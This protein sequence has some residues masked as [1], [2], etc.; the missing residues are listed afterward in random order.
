MRI[1]KLNDYLEAVD[2]GQDQEKL[3]EYVEG[4]PEWTKH[5]ENVNS[6]PIPCAAGD[7][8]P[9]QEWFE[10]QTFRPDDLLAEACEKL[11]WHSQPQTGGL[12]ENYYYEEVG[13]NG[14]GESYT[15]TSYVYEIIRDTL[16]CKTKKQMV[17]FLSSHSESLETSFRVDTGM[18]LPAF[19]DYINNYTEYEES[20]SEELTDKYW[21]VDFSLSKEV[22]GDHTSPIY[23]GYLIEGEVFN[24]FMQPYTNRDVF[25]EICK[26]LQSIDGATESELLKKFKAIE[27]NEDDK[28]SV[29]FELPWV[30]RGI[31]GEV[32]Q[33]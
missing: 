16:K 28:Y 31:P 32:E 25:E 24:G 14:W 10:L 21:P 11:G 6:K 1:L 30:G 3:A 33:Q 9:D 15:A 8:I 26:Y 19:I 17:S 27:P 12:L 5:V 23:T 20:T 29:G 4:H 7:G 22:E 2:M 18:D 13:G